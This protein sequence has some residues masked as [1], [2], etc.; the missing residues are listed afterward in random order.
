MKDI[1]LDLKVNKSRINE[2]NIY[3]N[4]NRKGLANLFIIIKINKENVALNRVVH[5]AET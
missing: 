1:Y 4:S 5:T 3:K 2:I